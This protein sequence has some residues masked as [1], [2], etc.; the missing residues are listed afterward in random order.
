[1]K[2]KEILEKIFQTIVKRDG[3]GKY[4]EIKRAV[5]PKIF[6]ATHRETIFQVMAKEPLWNRIRF[7]LL[8]PEFIFPYFARIRG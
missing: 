4:E 1:L 8:Y 6:R 5:T 7:F 2:E 3:K